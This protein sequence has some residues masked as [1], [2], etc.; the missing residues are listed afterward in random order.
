LVDGVPR[1]RYVRRAVARWII[2]ACRTSYAIEV[3]ESIWRRDEE[4]AAL[5]DNLEPGATQGAA[6]DGI[7]TAVP[8]PVLRPD[9]LDPSQLDLDVVIPLI[10]PGHRLVVEQE[11]RSLGLRSFRPL[12]DPTAVVAATA[13]IGEG[14]AVNAGVVVAGGAVL[15]RFV[16]VNRSASVGHHD[17]IADYATLGPGCV[18]A[19]HVTVERGAFVGA[20][21]VCAPQVTVGA[22]A[23]VG[24]GSVVV[25]D[26]QAGA[27]VAG[28]PAEPLPGRSGGYGGASVPL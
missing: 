4:V 9:G 1:S 24:A 16:H 28:N 20:G 12:L 21:A 17:V 2:Y 7:A 11:A 10:T 14:S 19:G 26:V 6:A 23:V 18:L 15:G 5:V 25:R 27:V 3:A 13:R 22:N 8:A